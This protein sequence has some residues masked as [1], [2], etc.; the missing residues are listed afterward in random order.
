MAIEKKETVKKTETK[1][2]KVATKKV[3][4]KTRVFVEFGDRQVVT[5][6]IV[7]AA[8][9]AFTKANKGVAIKN[10][11]VYI[12]PEEDVAYYVVNGQGADEYKVDL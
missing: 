8:T 9:K 7:A 4:P 5:K 2:A 12:K 6:D 3:E 10:M 11:D 1:T